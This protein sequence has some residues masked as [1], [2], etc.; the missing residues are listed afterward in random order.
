MISNAIDTPLERQ[1]T[2]TPANEVF[3]RNWLKPFGDTSASFYAA[4]TALAQFVA[5]PSGVF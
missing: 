5:D 2:F 1:A 4:E 3:G